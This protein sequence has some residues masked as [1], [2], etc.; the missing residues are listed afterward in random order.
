MGYFKFLHGSKII[1]L[2]FNVPEK[3]LWQHL[4]QEPE[5]TETH[6]LY[7][8]QYNTIA[9]HPDEQYPPFN[10]K[11]TTTIFSFGCQSRTWPRSGPFCWQTPWSGCNSGIDLVVVLEYA[12][13]QLYFNAKQI[14]VSLTRFRRSYGNRSAFVLSNHTST[15]LFCFTCAALFKV[16]TFLFFAAV[17]P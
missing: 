12:F 10:Q 11:G 7:L 16:V 14:F 1:W 4:F 15:L 2:P 8:S 6:S 3:L 17:C 5:E 9:T 13:F